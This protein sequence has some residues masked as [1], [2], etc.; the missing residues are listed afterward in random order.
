M[1][2]LIMLGGLLLA[3]NALA[4]SNEVNFDLGLVTIDDPTYDLFGDHN[5]LFGLGVTAGVVVWD[6][7][8]LLGVHLMGG[9]N[10]TWQSATVYGP[11]AEDFSQSSFDTSLFTDE[12]NLGPKVSVTLW[13]FLTPYLTVQG[14]FV[15]GQIKLDGDGIRDENADTFKRSAVT[16]GVRS[17]AGLELLIPHDRAPVSVGVY[18]EFGYA[19]YGKLKWKDF[20]DMQTRG[21]AFRS[22]IGLRF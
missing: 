12:F 14:A 11:Y 10:R 3:S 22:G 1:R 6:L 21:F 8:D 5:N 9:W 15:L 7:G 16:G 18:T 13:D 17:M 20:G 2:P 4:A 19:W